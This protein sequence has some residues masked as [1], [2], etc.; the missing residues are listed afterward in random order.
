MTDAQAPIPREERQTPVRARPSGGIRSLLIA[1]L[2]CAI[3]ALGLSG[4]ALFM[5]LKLEHGPAQSTDFAAEVHAYIESHPEV[6]VESL[7]N[8]E[9][10]QKESAAKEAINQLVA[11]SDEI[12]NDAAAPVVGNA[13]GDAT[14]VE[15]FDY[16]CPYCRKAA[17]VVDQLS[18]SDPKLKVVYKEYPILGPGSVFAARAALA[19]QKQGKYLPFHDALYAFH[20]P[21][22]ET[23]AMEVAAKV[24]LDIDRLKNDMA[25]PAIDNAIKRNAALAEA[26]GI[27]GTPTFVSRKEITPG[28]VDLDAL[29][30]MMANARKG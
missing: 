13:A 6:L 7:N 4:V 20:G 26:L 2:V 22:T 24:G 5:V 25:D 1:T 10:R 28:L 12:F 15:F 11:R 3:A 14:L 19:S 16:N 29:K 30:Q 8:A 23:S 17:P 9:S 27:S 21:I 18:Q